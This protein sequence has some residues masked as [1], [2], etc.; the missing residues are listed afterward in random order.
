MNYQ[1]NSKNRFL[2]NFTYL[3]KQFHT[4]KNTLD[5][6]TNKHPHKN[7]DRQTNRQ[8]LVTKKYSH[9]KL[10]TIIIFTERKDKNS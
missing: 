4:Q 10:W 9:Q 7:T 8:Q 2:I 3:K 6:Q 5:N 1:G